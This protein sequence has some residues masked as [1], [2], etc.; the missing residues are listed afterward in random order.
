MALGGR[1]AQE[2]ILGVTDTGASSDFQQARR[3]AY[4]YV[5]EYGMS[6][7]G[8]L[9]SVQG[10]DRSEEEKRLIESVVQKLLKDC[11][12]R[13]QSIIRQNRINFDRLVQELLVKETILGPEF[14]QILAGMET[15]SKGEVERD[16]TPEI[17]S[18]NSWT[19]TETENG[20]IDQ[21]DETEGDSTLGVLGRCVDGVVRG[22]FGKLRVPKLRKK[23]ED[24]LRAVS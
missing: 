17:E 6:E 18:D 22:A 8:P 19:D 21:T 23:S 3:L 11:E 4:M 9:T 20:S 5:A 10:I 16:F 14:A 24:A 13:A 12:E 15:T 2:M 7:L 1:A